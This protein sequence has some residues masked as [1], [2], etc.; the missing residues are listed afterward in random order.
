MDKFNWGSFHQHLLMLSKNR[1]VTT[2]LNH[3]FTTSC[4]CSTSCISS[5]YHQPIKEENLFFKKKS[6]KGHLEIYPKEGRFLQNMIDCS[7]Y[8][9]TKNRLQY[10]YYLPRNNSLPPIL[11]QQSGCR[12]LSNST[13]FSFCI[14]STK[15]KKNSDHTYNRDKNESNYRVQFMKQKIRNTHLQQGNILKRGKSTTANTGS[16]SKLNINNE[17]I[18]HASHKNT[19]NHNN[20]NNNP[21]ECAG[22]LSVEE[23]IQC[24]AQK[25]Q[26][27]V[28]MRTLLDTGRG[29]LIQRDGKFLDRNSYDRV[30]IPDEEHMLIQVAGFL[31]R[32]L[33]IR[34]S[35]RVRDLDSIP[36]LTDMPS[37]QEVRKL[38]VTSVD[39]IRSCEVPNTKER[40]EK[41]AQILD[42]I[43]NRHSAVLLNLAKGAY[44][45]RK[46][47]QQ[48]HPQQGEDMFYEL[49]IHSSFDKFILSRIGIRMLIGQYLELKKPNKENYIGLVNLATSPRDVALQAID[50]ATYMC[51]RQHG[52]APNVTVHGRVDLT[53]PY[54]PSHLHYILLELLKNSMRATVEYHSVDGEMPP[55]KVVIADGEENEDV[56]IKV[57][58]EGGGIRRSNMGRLWSYLFTTADPEVQRGVVEEATNDFDTASPLAGLGYGLPISRSYAR[59]FGGDLSVMSMEGYGTDAFV[60]L[61]RLGTHNEPLP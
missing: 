36:Y 12:S 29:K 42:N 57:S 3:S 21:I 16:N 1:R 46:N 37:A 32:E 28:S 41:F 17:D 15:D 8:Y 43:Y 48:T 13:P 18:I 10:S 27:G 59:Y 31:H 58:D 44:Q 52:D 9:Y 2:S 47:Y 55:I 19:N 33:P 4:L 23:Y 60:H 7:Y 35:H 25:S 30:D 56:V 50:D 39:Q 38:Y 51:T 14:N 5:I 11:N 20:G 61:S 24:N 34:L 22:I 6:K 45:L 53:F 40:E 26:T 49:D 54:V